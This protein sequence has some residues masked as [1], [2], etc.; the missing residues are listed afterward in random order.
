MKYRN[1]FAINEK[2]LVIIVK[3]IYLS[4]SIR[5]QNEEN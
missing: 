4:L 1:I 2:L 3:D 5:R